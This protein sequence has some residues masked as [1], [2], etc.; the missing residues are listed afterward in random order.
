[1]VFDVDLNK[2]GS[3]ARDEHDVGKAVPIDVNHRGKML[4]HWRVVRRS[5]SNKISPK[6][7]IPTHLIWLTSLV[8]K[9][10]S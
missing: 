2:A 1:M 8:A 6:L 5:I 4:V 9:F 3:L 7:S 10:L